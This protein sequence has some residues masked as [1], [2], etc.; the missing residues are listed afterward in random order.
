MSIPSSPSTPEP[1]SELSD[2][3]PQNQF[4][5]YFEYC[6]CTHSEGHNPKTCVIVDPTLEPPAA[7]SRAA[8]HNWSDIDLFCLAQAVRDVNPYRS[9]CVY[10]DPW[11]EI[12]S[13]LHFED[14]AH[15][16]SDLAWEKM[17]GL[18]GANQ[19]SC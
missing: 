5:Y 10:D 13:R 11:A 3:L 17:D 16:G 15:V 12:A 2:P 18:F 4:E 19:V 6:H 9:D 7:S 14:G 8:A 1:S